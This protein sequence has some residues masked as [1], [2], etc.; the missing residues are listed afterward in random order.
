[1]SENP[2]SG[3]KRSPLAVGKQK[4]EGLQLAEETFGP[5][6]NPIAAT[7]IEWTNYVANREKTFH[8][9]LGARNILPEGPQTPGPEED[10]FDSV[11]D[12]DDDDDPVSMVAQC[13]RSCVQKLEDEMEVK[14]ETLQTCIC[15][16]DCDVTF[17][18]LSDVGLTGFSVRGQL[19]AFRH[20]D[21]I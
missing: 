5:L 2:S 18:N 13:I 17:E 14:E 4:L 8:D 7:T 9:I 1:M 15:I 21:H 6:L 20:I 10:E 19:I 12:A 16:L 3:S 11:V